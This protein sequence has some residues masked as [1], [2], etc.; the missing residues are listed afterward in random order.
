MHDTNCILVVS[1]VRKIDSST[2]AHDEKGKQFFLP[3]R[4]KN[5][6][7]YLRFRRD[8]CISAGGNA[9]RPR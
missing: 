1:K 4:E 2:T 6:P 8:E 3:P 5:V 9:W 7:S